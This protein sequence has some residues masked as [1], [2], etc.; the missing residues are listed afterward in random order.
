MGLAPLVFE[1]QFILGIPAMGTGTGT[2]MGMGMGTGRVAVLAL[3]RHT[4]AFRFTR[5]YQKTE[6]NPF[7]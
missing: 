3:R 1:V 6:A 4:S 2:G 5:R 7:I